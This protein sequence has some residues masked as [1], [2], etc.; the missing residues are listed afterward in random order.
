MKFNKQIQKFVESDYIKLKAKMLNVDEETLELVEGE[1]GC[2]ACK[3]EK[4]LESVYNR[5]FNRSRGIDD[6]VED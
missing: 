2:G 3:F 4:M 5:L 6:E 1:E